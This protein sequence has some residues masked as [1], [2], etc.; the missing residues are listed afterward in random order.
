ME[1]RA[2]KKKKDSRAVVCHRKS[3]ARNKKVFQHESNLRKL[4]S[5]N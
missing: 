4:L 5:H 1:A 3:D 2:K